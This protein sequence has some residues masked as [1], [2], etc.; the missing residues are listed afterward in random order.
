[1][2]PC[3][4]LSTPADPHRSEPALEAPMAALD[5]VLVPALSDNYVYLLHDSDTGTTAVVDPGEAAPVEAALAERGWTLSQIVN[6]HHHHDHVGGNAELKAK[7][8]AQLVG[9]RAEAARI[10][11]MD[12]TVGA[13]D[14][15]EIA[16]HEIGR[17]HVWTPFT[18]A[19]LVCRLL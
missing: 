15:V 14:G 11:G 3:L 1:M 9:P 2:L 4:P 17:A 8:R 13:G 6:T 7:Y 10:P 5:V 18:N 16:G 19:H 12:L